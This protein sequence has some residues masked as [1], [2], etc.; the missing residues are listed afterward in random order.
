M[1]T[2]IKLIVGLGNPGAEHTETRHNVGFWFIDTL[3]KKYSLTF[4]PESKFQ[5]EVCRISIAD[6]DCWLCKPV[7]YMNVSGQAVQAI[8]NF[9]KIAID[10]ILVA[11]DEIDL[12]AGTVRLKKDGGHG[13][14]NGL[15]DIIEKINGKNFIRLRIGVSHPGSKEQ[16][17]PHVLG[18]PSAG[19]RKLINQTIDSAIEIM[20]QVFEGEVHKAMTAL[21]TVQHEPNAE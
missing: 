3:A 10:E 20:P 11:H 13:G 8:A 1:P 5:S 17:T 19:D 12:N 15:R 18:R 4:R 7:T 2:P 21:H 16:V 14:H 9:Y 6:I